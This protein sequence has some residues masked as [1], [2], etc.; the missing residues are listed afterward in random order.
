MN[1]S[2]QL[3]RSVTTKVSRFGMEVKT[4]G[5]FQNWRNPVY[6][7][8]HVS[9]LQVGPDY[10]FQDGRR[11]QFTSKAELNRKFEQ[12]QLAKKIVKY[13]SEIKEMENMYD[14]GMAEREAREAEFIEW[15]PK[16]KS[17]ETIY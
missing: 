1:N 12:V 7:S 4:R 14:K 5:K 15:T 11:L 3:V 13:L 10:S 9:P 6:V 17:T 8:P 2:I 16:Q